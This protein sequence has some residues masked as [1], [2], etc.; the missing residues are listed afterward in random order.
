MILNAVEQQQGLIHGKL[1]V[2]GEYRAIGSYFEVNERT[3]L[4]DSLID[5]VAAVND[6]MPTLTPIQRKVRMVRWLKWKLADL[7]MAGFHK[8]K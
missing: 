7:G 6:S 3:C 2:K 4:P 8:R 5:E 1:E